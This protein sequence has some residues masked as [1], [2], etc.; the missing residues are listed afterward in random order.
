MWPVLS[1]ACSGTWDKSEEMSLFP[2][3]WHSWLEGKLVMLGT[4]LST[5]GCGGV[6]KGWLSESEAIQSTTDLWDGER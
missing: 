6:G 3:W 2:A 5:L 1:S 4:L